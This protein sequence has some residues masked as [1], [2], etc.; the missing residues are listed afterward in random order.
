MYKFIINKN[1]SSIGKKS[2][3]ECNVDNNPFLSYTFLK[4][5]EDS[6]S[7]G[8]ETSWIPN[9]ISIVEK[10]NVV[11]VSPIYIKLDSQGEYIF[12]HSW[13]N[14]YY[15]A[16]GKYYPKIQSSV[17]FTPVTGNRILINKKLDLNKARNIIEAFG[18]FLKEFTNDNYSSAHITFCSN[19]EC[20]I[21]ENKN[22]LTR[23]GEQYHWKND[24]YKNFEDFLNSLNSRKRKAISKERKYI[25]NLDLKILIKSGSDI[26]KADWDNMYEFYRNTTNK[27]WGQ[28]YLNKKFFYLLA[29]NFS[30]K[31]LLIF[32]EKNNKTVAGALHVIGENTLYGR[33]WGSNINIKYLHFELC[34]YQAI[35]WAIKNNLNFV[36]GGAQGAHKIQR[37]YLPVKT[38]ST[39]YIVNE[40]FRNAVKN[41]L[42]EEIQL[43][44]ND[45]SLINNEYS[46]FKKIN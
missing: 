7:V 32:A 12:D 3:Q 29:K 22:F 15:N 19:Y 17:P 40:S 10:K 23:I 25:N 44:N 27:K 16:G 33:Y 24:K 5:L 45:I 42:T 21:L 14:A 36:E 1:I 11:G 28:A 43:I 8:Q 39:H 2:W 26:S 37:G 38:Y 18:D 20:S 34:Y 13:A 31:I 46:P 4:N 9:Y 35:E 41:F 30:S 6:N